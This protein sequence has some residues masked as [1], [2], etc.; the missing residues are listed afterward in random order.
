MSQRRQ[1]TINTEPH[2]A[3]IGDVELLFQP[4]VMGDQF[5]DAYED[6][7]QTQKQLGVDINNLSGIAPDKLRAIV[8]SL[9]V[10]LAK[11]MLPESAQ[12]F[13][14]WEVVKGGKAVESFGTREEADAHAAESKGS[15]VRDSG[16]RLPD[17]VLVELLEWAVELYGGGQRPTGLSGGSAAASPPPGTRGRAVSSSKGSTRTRGR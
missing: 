10:F 4:E 7:Q 12:V 8:Q 1:F 11:L 3:E 15:T 16:M 14:R 6:L 5:L 17:R 13:A 2:V 9:R